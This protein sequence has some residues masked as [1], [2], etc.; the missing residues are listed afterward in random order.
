MKCTTVKQVFFHY[1][2]FIKRH[3]A[4][5]NSAKNVQKILKRRFQPALEVC[6]TQMQVKI[7]NIT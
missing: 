4:N 2:F 6:N 7:Y 3:K 1:L 5:K